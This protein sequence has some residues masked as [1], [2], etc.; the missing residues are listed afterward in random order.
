MDSDKPDPPA[1]AVSNAWL[2]HCDGSAFPNPGNMGLGAILI[3]PDGTRHTLSETATGKGCN[4]EAEARAMMAAL[5]EAKRLGADCVR[6]HS[7]SRVVVDQLTGDG[8][9]PIERLDALF[10]E[11][12]AQLAAFSGSTV[13]WIPQHRNSEA[14]A[15]ARNAAGL[16]PR[17]IAKPGKGRKRKG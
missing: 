5:H 7:D 15:L 3:G 6:I 11:M 8:G 17:P 4:N 16:P 1:P 2:L 14:D 10:T 9:Q 12:R 13:K